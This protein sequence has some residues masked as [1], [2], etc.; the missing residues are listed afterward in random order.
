MTELDDRLAHLEAQG[1]EQMSACD[2]GQKRQ[3]K[4]EEEL[5]DMR[6]VWKNVLKQQGKLADSPSSLA[7]LVKKPEQASDSAEG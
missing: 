2:S 3:P 1:L 6:S 4:S 7:S 5:T